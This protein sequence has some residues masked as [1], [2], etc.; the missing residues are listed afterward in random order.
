LWARASGSPPGSQGRWSLRSARWAAEPTPTEKSA[1]L[2]RVLLDRYGVLTREATHAEGIAGGFSAVYDVL[3]A[4]E[5]SARIRR[6]YFVAERG[7]TQFA[8]PGAD[9]RLRSMRSGDEVPRVLVL[10]ATDP[11]NPYGATLPWPAREARVQGADASEEKRRPQRAAGARVILCDGALVG[12]LGRGMETLLTFLPAEEPERSARAAALANA[13]AGLVESGQRRALLLTT[14]DDASATASALGAALLEAG[15]TVGGG[16]YLRRRAD[17]SIHGRRDRDGDRD[18]DRL[19]V[20]DRIFGRPARSDRPPQMG[21]PREDAS[22][23]AEHDD[24]AE[25]APE[26]DPSSDY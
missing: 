10:A 5:D 8:L 3:K 20:R 21:G 25:Y 19:S 23:V 1:A 15:F 18:R 9:D 2:A 13:L 14:I 12:W 22:G 6:G 16:G 4:M 11:A 24:E 17:A 26:S 7:A